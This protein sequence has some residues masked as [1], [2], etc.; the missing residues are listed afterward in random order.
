MDNRGGARGVGGVLIPV[1]KESNRPSIL[2]QVKT[3]AHSNKIF[4]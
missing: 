4:I 1:P 3:N 2:G